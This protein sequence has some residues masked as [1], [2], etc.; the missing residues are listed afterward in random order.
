[1]T[2]SRDTIYKEAL[3]IISSDINALFFVV[4]RAIDIEV[5]TGK[6]K[7]VPCPFHRDTVPSA[8]YF[9]DPE[10][11]KL[12]CFGCR[13]QY[14]SYHYIKQIMEKKP[15]NI[16]I[17]YVKKDKIIEAVGAYKSREI[18]DGKERDYVSLLKEGKS[19][20]EVLREIHKL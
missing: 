5:F 8:I 7:K 13:K 16:L 15:L 11:Q 18:G 10:F 6:G 3:K 9:D 1:M 12:H 19:L 14:T 2:S 4:S 17:Q 20:N